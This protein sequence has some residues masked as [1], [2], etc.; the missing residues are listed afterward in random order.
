[1]DFGREVAK[2]LLGAYMFRKKNNKAALIDK[3]I[4]DL[5][6]VELFKVHGRGINGRTARTRLKLNI[7]LRGKKDPLWEKVWE[8]YTRAT[9][10]IGGGSVVKMFETEHE[11]LV[12]GK[13]V[14]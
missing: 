7:S 12:A 9:V 8:Y 5:T 11:L 10:T 13:N 1:M 3:V 4:K 14:E 2:D 6:S